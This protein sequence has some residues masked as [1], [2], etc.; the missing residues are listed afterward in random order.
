M[1]VWVALEYMFE[2]LRPS[3][4]KTTCSFPYRFSGKNRNS[5][6]V[7]GN[8][9]PAEEKLQ[10][11]SRRW[12]EFSSSHFPCRKCLNLDGDSILCCRQM[13]EELSS[14]AEICSG[15]LFQQIISDSHSLLELSDVYGLVAF[16][17]GLFK[18]I[19]DS[20]CSG[21]LELPAMLRAYYADERSG[22]LSPQARMVPAPVHLSSKRA[23]P[24]QA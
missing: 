12:G 21:L 17:D 10:E 22:S 9:D 23:K 13:G 14:S 20:R 5:G 18:T 3:P 16:N 15:K 11:R 8:R 1:Q 6:L 19:R 24:P 2:T 4:E 7:P